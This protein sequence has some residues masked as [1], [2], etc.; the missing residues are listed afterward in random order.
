M[1]DFSYQN[2]YTPKGMQNIGLY[3]LFV[4]LGLTE[5]AK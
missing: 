4:Y 5:Y 2:S 1:K 3:K